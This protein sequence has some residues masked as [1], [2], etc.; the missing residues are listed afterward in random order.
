[1]T[2]SPM[3]HALASHRAMQLG[4]RAL[5]YV[6]GGLSVRT[7]IDCSGLAVLAW[8]AGDVTLPHNTVAISQDHQVKYV[9][10]VPAN[11]AKLQLGDLVFFPG[12]GQ[13]GKPGTFTSPQHMAVYVGEFDAM[14]LIAQ[15]T[16]PGT[17]SEVIRLEKY[18]KPIAYGLV[19]HS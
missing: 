3:Q 2:I 7:G 15:A 4:Y 9:S 19:G 18:G 10:P 13:D 17:R 6:F 14:T 16:Q 12:I 5:P 8:K 11:L 1:M